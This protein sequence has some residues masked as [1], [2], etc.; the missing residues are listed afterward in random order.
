MSKLYKKIIK[1]Y[2]KTII[3]QTV[4]QVS[5]H[6]TRLGVALQKQ[7]KT[8]LIRQNS[9]QFFDDK[10]ND[11]D[12]FHVHVKRNHDYELSQASILAAVS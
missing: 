5:L 9:E 6:S 7:E 8:Q 1:E 10:Y 12:G 3:T 2:N 4:Y 11:D